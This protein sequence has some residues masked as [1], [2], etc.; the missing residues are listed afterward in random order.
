MICKG[1]VLNWVANVWPG[2][3]IYMVYT[4]SDFGLNGFGKRSKQLKPGAIQGMKQCNVLINLKL[5]HPYPP[6]PRALDCCLCLG[7]R[8]FDTGIPGGGEFGLQ[9]SSLSSGIHMVVPG[10]EKSKGKEVADKPRAAVLC[11]IF[12]DM[13]KN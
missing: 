13:F 4:R 7:S 1:Q 6:P 10:M 11:S 2:H 3:K 9:L 8:K 5:Q 12:E